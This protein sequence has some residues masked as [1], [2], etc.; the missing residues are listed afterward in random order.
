[1]ETGPD[2][3]L[4]RLINM[5]FAIFL[6]LSIL[7]AGVCLPP[8]SSTSVE[9]SPTSCPVN[10]NTPEG[11]TFNPTEGHQVVGMGDGDDRNP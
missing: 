7:I 9:I 4:W 3:P 8:V 5:K 1:M 6:G 11:L 2:M 10:E